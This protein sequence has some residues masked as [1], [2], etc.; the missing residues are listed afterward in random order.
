MLVVVSILWC[1]FSLY[2]GKK[3]GTW[4]WFARAGAMITFAGACLSGSVIW[5]T[6]RAA[7]RDANWS[8]LPVVFE[9]GTI[10]YDK[11][12]N[13]LIKPSVETL[14]QRREN[15]IEALTASNGLIL[16]LIGTVIWAYGDWLLEKWFPLIHR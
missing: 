7:Q 15:K 1:L 6:A 12:G 2:L 5:R 4:E 16:G 3:K 13:M 10:E 8:G 11:Q 14:R 9:T